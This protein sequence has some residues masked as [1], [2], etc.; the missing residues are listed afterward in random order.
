[1]GQKWHP[2]REHL[3]LKVFSLGTSFLVAFL[4]LIP[5]AQASSI[6]LQVS[7]CESIDR[8]PGWNA[9]EN[10]KKGDSN[11]NVSAGDK[12][13]GSVSG[14]F[15]KVSLSCGSTVGLHLS[16]NS[17]DVTINIYRM[18]YY[19]GA[20]ARLVYSRNIGKVAHAS[21]PII[22]PAP[23]LTVSTTWDTTVTIEINSSFPTGIYETRFD[24]GS[25]PG[26][27]PF[28]V[29]DDL[30]HTP[31]L[32]VAST[33]TWQGYNTWGGSNLYRSINTPSHHPARVVSFDRPYD[34]DGKSNF[35]LNEE[36]IVQ[37]AESA[38]LDI[39]YASDNDLDTS[40]TNLL[41]YKTIIFGGHSEYWSPP[42]QNGVL[43]ARN[44]G[45]NI[46]FFGGNQAYWRVRMENSGRDLAVWKGDPLDPF[47]SDPTKS[48]MRWGTYPNTGNQSSL[49]GAFFA[50]FGVSANYKVING[51][52]WPI[53]GS[54]L[55]TGSLISGVVGNEVDTTDKGIAPG[56][57]TFLT[58][59]VAINN[60]SYS[61]NLTYYTT[62]SNSGVID[63]STT[64]W[65]CSMTS[66][67]LWPEPPKSTSAAVI[68]ITQ[69]ILRAAADG[70]L[71]VSHP[72]KIDIA[73]RTIMVNVGNAIPPL[74]QH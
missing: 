37:A 39:S 38:K 21:A 65:V 49:L 64:G 58:S 33:M 25:R 24:D 43:E 2:F 62:P 60:L 11:W 1:M 48:T 67:C 73:P 31:L 12:Y 19:D 3:L 8:A 41:L 72:A 68:K 22:S 57:Q 10:A 27:A 4:I 69:S 9:R 20:G 29:R 59:T 70:P 32:L 54:G 7:N 30:L 71:G 44:K 13:S 23:T 6:K 56:V 26:F 74:T 63:V 28:I 47:R 66:T 36:G 50:G 5:F 45:I 18:G 61:V 34:K 35:I 46:L 42:M 40:Q 16:G 17:R 51:D 15:D 52:I 53:V 55:K 14:W